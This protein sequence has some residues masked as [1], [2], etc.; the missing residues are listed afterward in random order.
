MVQDVSKVKNADPW[1]QISTLFPE[2]RQGFKPL[3]QS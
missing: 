1:R 2:V 3:T